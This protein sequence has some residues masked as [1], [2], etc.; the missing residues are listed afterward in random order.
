MKNLFL[1]ILLVVAIAVA[2]FGALIKIL[3]KGTSGNEIMIFAFCL[4]GLVLIA[5][6]WK[7]RGSII[8]WLKQ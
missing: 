4:K 6:I 3:T 1:L 8:P 7:N 2:S 5:L